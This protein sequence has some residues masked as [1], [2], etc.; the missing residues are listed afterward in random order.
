MRVNKNIDVSEQLDRQLEWAQYSY[1]IVNGWI[2]NADNKVSVACAVFTGTFGVVTFLSEQIEETC[3]IS[4]FWQAV[5]HYVGVASLLGLLLAMLFF[6][7]AL[8]PSLISTNKSKAK[9]TKKTEAYPI[10]F[11]DIAAM[12]L[13]QYKKAMEEGENRGLF[14]ALIRDTHMNAGICSRKMKW[15]KRGLWVSFV[16]IALSVLSLFAHYAMFY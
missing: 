10:Y 7:I 9:T 5:Y 4:T 16:T 12:N 1:G 11:G 13:K 14:D 15:Y 2:E 6:V 8:S 3:R